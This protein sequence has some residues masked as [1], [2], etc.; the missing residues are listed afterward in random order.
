M[1]YG[2]KPGRALGEIDAQS[3]GEELERIHR[4]HKAIVPKK[5][6][7]ESRPKT[8][9]LHPHFEWNDK[10]AAEEYRVH[11][12]R[13]IIGSVVVV[14]ETENKRPVQA[15]INVSVVPEGESSGDHENRGRA[16]LP[17]QQVAD[18]PALRDQHLANLK[19]R[20]KNMRREHAAFEEL[21]EVWS[22]VDSLP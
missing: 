22:A 11:Q 15:F 14:P 6:V 9:V 4:K 10:V 1:H 21:A 16:Y 5:V 3:V 18:D 2:W 13:Q 12:A 17:A 19:L 20:L 7:E 8:A